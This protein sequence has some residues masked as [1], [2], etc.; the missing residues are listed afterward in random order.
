MKKST[1]FVKVERELL[2]DTELS[3]G[4]L[5][6]LLLLREVAWKTGTT[7]GVKDGDRYITQRWMAD[8]LGVSLGTISNRLTE[9]REHELV[10][11][12]G[13]GRRRAD[14]YHLTER[15]ETPDEVSEHASVQS[16][17][18]SSVQSDEHSTPPS[19]QS[20]ERNEAR[21][22]SQLGVVEE[23]DEEQDEEQLQ[24]SSSPSVS[25]DAVARAIRLI[26]GAGDEPGL[27]LSQDVIDLKATAPE[28]DWID[29]ARAIFQTLIDEPSL[30]ERLNTVV[31]EG[32]EAEYPSLRVM[33]ARI[34]SLTQDPD[35]GE[36]ATAI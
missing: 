14:D 1:R 8:T 25:T 16:A 4:A 22:F 3:D 19:V 2:R 12:V 17:E 29:F 10:S 36:Q 27:Q 11:V 34:R 13:K 23:V 21:V 7:A 6:L 33:T 15:S 24:D 5:R 20:D 31:E 26:Q 35:T 28:S 32:L 30:D 18:H 9:L